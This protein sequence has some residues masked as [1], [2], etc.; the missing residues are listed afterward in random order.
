[1]SDKKELEV[2]SVMV[3]IWIFHLFYD[4]LNAAKPKGNSPKAKKY[5][6][7]S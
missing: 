5:C 3:L 4:H 6:N 1:M 2:I 7:S